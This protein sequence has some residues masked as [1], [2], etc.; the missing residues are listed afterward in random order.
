MCAWK[1]VRR[2]CV[3]CV[4]SDN[5]SLICNLVD[6]QQQIW[7]WHCVKVT[8]SR[9]WHIVNWEST[10]QKKILWFNLWTN[11]I[12]TVQRRRTRRRTRNFQLGFT[13]AMSVC[14]NDL[15][16]W[17]HLC[18]PSPFISRNGIMLDVRF[19]YWKYEVTLCIHTGYVTHWSFPQ[20]L[21]T[22]DT[23]RKMS[24]K[25]DFYSDFIIILYH[26]EGSCVKFWHEQIPYAR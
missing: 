17:K 20:C 14:R 3:V 1:C 2:V 13:L 11:V 5:F 22:S 23:L 7:C 26:G 9:E 16:N 4:W 21:V 24:S 19:Q 15:S 12:S 25:L 6:L 8:D 10:D 18:H